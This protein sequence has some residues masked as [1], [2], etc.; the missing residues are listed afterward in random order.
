[1]YIYRSHLEVALKSKEFASK[2]LKE[3]AD[4]GK[5]IKSGNG[6]MTWSQRRNG[7]V[8]RMLKFKISQQDEIPFGLP[9]GM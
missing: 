5:L 6:K 9:D 1:M 2:I 4:E 8:S 3:L 7:S